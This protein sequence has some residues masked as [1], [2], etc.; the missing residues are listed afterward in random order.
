MTMTRLLVNQPLSYPFRPNL[1]NAIDVMDTLALWIGRSHAHNS[2]LVYAKKAV[3]H[4]AARRAPPR[5]VRTTSIAFIRVD[6]GEGLV[7]QNE[8]RVYTRGPPTP[9]IKPGLLWLF[10]TTCLCLQC[11]TAYG[12]HQPVDCRQ[13]SVKLR[14]RHTSPGHFSKIVPPRQTGTRL[15][16]FRA[17]EAHTNAHTLVPLA[18]SASVLCHA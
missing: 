3:G 11:E 9:V 5:Q 15:K 4:R 10:L 1:P 7:Y 14:L 17:A 18:S 12:I 16:P 13:C 8:Y 6:V 2:P